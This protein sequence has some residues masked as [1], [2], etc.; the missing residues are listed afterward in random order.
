MLKIP[1]QVVHHDVQLLLKHCFDDECS[2]VWEKEETS[3]LARRLSRMKDS[4]IIFERL[5]WFFDLIL[6]HAIKLSELFK[7]AEGKVRNSNFLIYVLLFVVRV[8]DVKGFL[9][10]RRFLNII[11]LAYILHKFMEFR[12]IPVDGIINSYLIQLHLSNML[13]WIH[14]VHIFY[15]WFGEWLIFP[16]RI[17]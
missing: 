10:N 11:I 16:D 4:L 5:K 6:V 7:L 15:L 17:S 9:G 12:N 1:R 13:K 3:R 8:I 2:I 14:I